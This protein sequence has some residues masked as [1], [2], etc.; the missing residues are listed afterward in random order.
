MYR[1]LASTLLALSLPIALSA[2]ERTEFTDYRLDNGLRVILVEDN[3]VPIVTVNVWYDVGSANERTGRSGFAHLF[4]HMMFEGSKNVANDEHSSL[5][6][7]AGG[8]LNGTTDEDR[9]AYFETLPANR[10]NL[11]LWLEADRMRSLT[12][13][14]ENLDTQRNAVQEERRLRIDNQ[15]YAGAFLASTTMLY[16]STTCFPYAHEVI[17][18][19]EDLNA[20]DATDVQEFFD[21]YYAPGNATLVVVGDFDEPN[22]RKLIRQYFS[23]IPGRDTPRSPSC[24]W[25]VGT[26]AQ[27]TVWEDPLA[28]LPMVLVGFR[29][30]AHDHNDAKAIQLLASIL[31]GG[32]SSRLNRALVR[33]AQSAVQT[34]SFSAQHRHGSPFTV[35]AIANQGVDAATIAD[36]L[37]A[38]VARLI[39]DGVTEAELEK[40][41][42]SYRSSDIFGRQTTFAVAQN[43]QHYAHFHDSLAEMYTD[44]DGY[45][46]VT[47]DDMLRVARTYLA[48]E[49]S[50]T[51]TVVP[52]TVAETPVP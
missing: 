12:I 30:P 31:G 44:L 38:E 18:S 41:K 3:S 24:E 2:Q 14:T 46:D 32:E 7:R 23:D 19:M 50:L 17:G 21:A 10:L 36:Q 39:T 28:N 11:G 27:E 1:A 47:A 49:N 48:R 15:P 33:N 34:A 22:A 20:A 13:T 35:L 51:I 4:E 52:A 37:H 5:I 16:D 29:T 26:E 8:T 43:I 40:A 6:Q 9:T 42:N 45:M 25:S